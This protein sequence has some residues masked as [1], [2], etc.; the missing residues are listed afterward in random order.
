MGRTLGD[1]PMTPTPFA[2]CKGLRSRKYHNSA[3]VNKSHCSQNGTIYLAPPR[4]AVMVALY[5]AKIDSLAWYQFCQSVIIFSRSL[6]S[7]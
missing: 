7:W 4:G 1:A 6:A 5:L 3:A 2:L